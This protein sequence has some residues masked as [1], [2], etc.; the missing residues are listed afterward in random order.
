MQNVFLVVL[1]QPK[2]QEVESS[3]LKHNL[4]TSTDSTA[5][6][7]LDSSLTLTH[8]MQVHCPNKI[9]IQDFQFA[10]K[11]KKEKKKKPQKRVST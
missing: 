6:Y 4:F 10:K 1:P 11:K 8:F 7:T 3:V 5:Y 2:K 9:Q